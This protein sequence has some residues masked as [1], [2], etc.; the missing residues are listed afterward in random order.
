MAS[1]KSTLPISVCQINCPTRAATSARVG[2]SHVLVAIRHARAGPAHERDGCPASSRA[3]L[4][5]Q[6]AAADR[7]AH[8]IEHRGA[9]GPSSP[10]RPARPTVPRARTRG[11]RPRRG[12]HP[13]RARPWLSRP[14]LR[15][16][17]PS[18]RLKRA[19]CSPQLGQEANA[20]GSF[21]RSRACCLVSSPSLA[22]PPLDVIPR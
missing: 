20:A 5:G 4:T 13:V 16:G 18:R 17:C 9:R 6:A 14:A 11:R 3:R 19:T 21:F 2:V 22:A 10:V 8:R 15:R 7:V 1:T 12:A